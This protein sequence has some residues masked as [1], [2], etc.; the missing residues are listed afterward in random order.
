MR[1]LENRALFTVLL[2][3]GMALSAP[4]DGVELWSQKPVVRPPVP[5]GATQSK[6]PIDSDALKAQ[7]LLKRRA[8]STEGCFS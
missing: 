1:G 6:N 3:S 5:A 2:L 7:P 4:K 8:G